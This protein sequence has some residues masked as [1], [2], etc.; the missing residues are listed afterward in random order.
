MAKFTKEELSRLH[1]ETLALSHGFDPWLSEG[2]V[3]P[4]AFLTST[5]A[6]KHAADGKQFFAWLHGHGAPKSKDEMGL[7]YSRINNPN[8]E[9]FED[10][11]C[12]WEGMKNAISFSSGMAAI[13]TTLLSVLNPGDEIIACEPVYGGTDGFMH[14]FLVRYGITT[15]T[16]R[17][18]VDAPA[19]AAKLINNKTRCIFIE[20]PA[21]PNNALT[22]I[23]EMKKLAVKHGKAGH[24]IYVMVDNTLAGPVFSKPAKFGADIVLYSAT[25]FIGGHSDLVAGVALTDDAEIAK[26]IVCGRSAL[27][28]M[29]NAYTAWLL[30]RSLETLKIRMEA[31]QANA[32][33]V[34]DYLSKH[35]KVKKVYYLGLIKESDP[36]YRVFKKQYTGSG[37]LMSV[38]IVGGEKECF[39]FLDSLRIFKVAVSLGSTESLAQHPASMTHS[40]VSDEIKKLSSISDSMARLSIGIENADDLIWDLDQALGNVK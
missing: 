32:I 14:D 36:D 24:P 18:G 26:K 34:A 29:P 19:E 33:K 2:A 31:A 35:P 13:S 1:P 30:T 17:A 9:I 39:K 8:L 7:V 25:K 22:D 4:P 3:K 38:D 27:G 40:A 6:F 37:S 28:G 16:V 5:F 20:T 15:K 11:I 10:R 23:E 21:N 12:A